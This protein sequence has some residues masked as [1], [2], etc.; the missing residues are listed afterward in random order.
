MEVKSEIV[1]DGTIPEQLGDVR[2]TN[3]NADI[4]GYTVNESE[5]KGIE[6]S[7]NLEMSESGEL[8]R[9]YIMSEGFGDHHIEVY[10]NWIQKTS[11]N[12]IYG[13]VI[14][15]PDNKFIVFENLRIFG[16]RYINDGKVLPLTP[17]LAREQ[18]VSYAC[19]WHVDIV[20]KDNT[21][22]EYDKKQGVCI[23]TVPLMLKSRNCVLH[24][25]TPAELIKMGE[26]PND[27]GGYFI[28]AGNEK[29]AY[30]KTVLLQE[31][32]AINRIFIMKMKSDKP[33]VTRMTTA[34]TRGTT[35]IELLLPK[36]NMSA[37]E[38]KL[39]SLKVKRNGEI[40][41]PKSMNVIRIFRI[42]G[43]GNIMS[44]LGGNTESNNPS[45]IENA[46]KQSIKEIS[47]MISQF[48]KP[49][50]REKCLLKMTRTFMESIIKY[51]DVEV[52]GKEFEKQN[53]SF[54]ERIRDLNKIVEYDLFPHVNNLPG[55][56][57]ET[58]EQRNSR[59]ILTKVHSLAIMVAKSLE[60]MAGFT[61]LDDRDSWSNKRVEGAGRMMEQL[62][63]NTWKKTAAIIQGVID[64][65]QYLD[66]NT[67]TERIKNNKITE[68][69]KDSFSTNS[70]GVK[71]AKMKNNVT[72]TL[73]RDSVVS[74]FAHINTVDVAILRQD[75]QAGIRLIQN[76]QWGFI[77][78]LSSPEGE[79]CGIIKN[80]SV[81]AKVSLERNDT[82]IIR[83]LVG[84]I[85]RGLQ[86]MVFKND[87]IHND[88]VMVNGKFLGW[89]N[90]IE[91]K[92]KLIYARRTG[93]N[94]IHTDTCVV[95][96]DDWLYVDVTPSR[97]I[98]P[99]LIVNE[100]TQTLVID[101]LKIRDQQIGYLLTSG[102][103]EYISSWEQE[104]LK[105]A[106]SKQDII[107]RNALLDER[108]STVRNAQNYYDQSP[109][110]ENKNILNDAIE[111]YNKFMKTNKPYT[112][113]EIDPKAIIGVA[114]CLIPWP[115]HNQAPRNTYQVSMGKQA[116]GIYHNN[117]MNR[118]DGK[119]KTLAFPNRPIVET[120]MYNI[121]GLDEKGPGENVLMAFMAYPNTEEDSFVVKK[122][123][124][125]NGG[126]RIY[127]YI[128]YKTIV[129]HTGNVNDFLTKPLLRPGEK[130]D[131]YKYIQM[132]KAN[133][134]SNGL[135]MIGAPLRQGDCVIGK[136]QKSINSN[137]DD[138]NESTILRVG[139]EGIVDK[140]LVSSDSKTTVVT[141]K[142]RLMRIPQEGD[143]FAP[144][145]AQKGT[146]GLVMSDIDLP[147]TSDGLVPDFI[148]NTHCLPSRLTASYVMEIIAATHGAYKGKHINGS[149][150]EPFRMNEY[151]QTL[152]ERGK[153]EF[154]YETMTSGN[155]G[156]KLKTPIYTGMVF[157]QALKHHVKDKIQ[158]RSTGAVKSITH[159]P[160]K[161]RGNIGGLRFGEME[162]DA[163]ISHGASAFLKERLM[164][165][166]DA[167]ETVL[168]RTCGSYGVYDSVSRN[169][170]KYRTCQMCNGT[171]FGKCTIPYAYKLL[172]HLLSAI[173]INLR[174]NVKTT[175]EYAE[176]IVS[177]IHGDDQE[178]ITGFDPNDEDENLEDEQEDLEQD[179][180][181]EDDGFVDDFME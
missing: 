7:T 42:L 147:R 96:E 153:D 30:E 43:V 54:E 152:K 55:P 9:K 124:L 39:P 138:R 181:Y 179:N 156:L 48:I 67:I 91:V 163:A 18:G 23:A 154:C 68:T 87:G 149:A 79:N 19:D 35:L 21:G 22:K 114:G 133:D 118:F 164:N 77:C 29:V 165:A 75:K 157:F 51:N 74:T 6:G 4:F 155:T 169:K 109:T 53:A 162:R 97:L 25:K 64:N 56:N 5:N 98:R 171:E 60:Y 178:D 44:K 28:V 84:D 106:P 65:K 17:K 70:W 47:D 177:K 175:D 158:A 45:E 63:R 92:Q 76:S 132:G 38:I 174:P 59:I 81:T 33:A 12:N 146:I 82:E 150:F 140:I 144:R 121:L 117:H 166:S 11:Y 2:Y 49:E 113:C 40:A 104:Y 73:V 119:I 143:K 160:P 24:G 135:P 111:L 90:G 123:F 95:L 159:Q 145:N 112:H 31:Q 134:P 99:V 107:Q 69:F 129:K 85:E 50:W 115:N 170:Y 180:D 127:K 72:Q 58:P 122:E 168:C 142:L 161:G 62:L 151:R 13:I 46:V 148:I 10:D 172:Q 89:C 88:K 1:S 137:E 86:P 3:F 110:Q 100:E 20:M 116:L 71:G 128:S 36:D 120:E 105:I 32:L 125:E 78:P 15:L 16:P 57:N 130:V 41:K 167:Y 108:M 136:V 131:R 34:T 66:M 8:L 102:A 14:M 139:D 141:V 83:F 37:I 176:K 27:P 52:F 103:M 61:E 101:D 173:G 80:L 93:E 26:D 126:F 94:G